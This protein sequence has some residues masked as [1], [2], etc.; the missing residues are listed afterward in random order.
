[1]TNKYIFKLKNKYI[2]VTVGLQEIMHLVREM[3]NEM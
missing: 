2:L 3:T 1:M